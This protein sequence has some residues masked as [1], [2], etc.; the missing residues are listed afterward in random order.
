MGDRLD[1][2]G[3]DFRVGAVTSGMTYFAGIP[4][5]T[6]SLS[7][8][9][10][11]WRSAAGTSRRRSSRA[12]RPAAVPPGLAV[13]GNGEVEEDLGRPVQPGA[14][15][16]RPD[17]GAVVDR[18]RGHHRRGRLPVGARTGARP[19]GAEGDRRGDARPGRRAVLQAALLSLLA[20]LLSVGL[21]EAI[22]PA[23]AMSVEVPA[24]TF[25]T[26]PIV[27]VL[28]G[29]AGEPD[30]PA[31]RGGR[32]PGAG[33]R[34]FTMTL[35]CRDLVVEYSG[36]GYVV[37][38]DRRPLARG[39]ERRAG[40]AA[41]R[42]RMRQD[43]AAVDPRGDP[44]APA[45]ERAAQRHEVTR[46]SGRALTE[47]RRHSVGVVFQ[48]FNLHPQPD[49]GG[50]RAGTPPGRRCVARAGRAG[51]PRSC[52]PRSGWP[53][54]ACT[55]PGELSGGE[56]QRVATA[57]ALALDPPLLLADEPTAHLDYIQIEGVLRLLREI[58][59]AGRMVVVA[60]HDE[61]MMPL[62]DRTIELSPR[63]LEGVPAAR[64]VRLA[65]GGDPVPAG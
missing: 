14:T 18:G 13:L 58:A 19:G 32:R 9:A 39:G 8:R 44:A 12:G 65:A 40:A 38:P 57:R 10:S 53:S 27:A 17:P 1:L 24:L 56:Q 7:R 5:V 31:A 48:A 21:E 51:A 52:S 42:E 55:G 28:V 25:L 41:G 45:R 47:Y 62:A 22:A 34:G 43:D 36:G 29:V 30:R 35:E 50:E 3:A 60:T 37:R 4:T 6:V 33:V 11:G 16:D 64:E 54:A 61:R 49:R 26:L 23:V 59:D 20:A 15:D 63:H 46:L 2:N